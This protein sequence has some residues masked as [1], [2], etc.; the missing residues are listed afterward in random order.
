MKVLDVASS[1]YCGIVK[2]RD[3]QDK[4]HFYGLTPNNDYK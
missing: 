3:A 1:Y 2:V 4:I